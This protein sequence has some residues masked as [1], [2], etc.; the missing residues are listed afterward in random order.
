MDTEDTRTFTDCGRVPTVCRPRARPQRGSQHGGAI[1]IA[2]LRRAMKGQFRGVREMG[3]GSATSR[4]SGRFSRMR[5]FGQVGECSLQ[6]QQP[7]QRWSG[8]EALEVP[9]HCG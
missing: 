4:E 3:A 5:G 1:A 8:K 7:V 2:V 6:G 9:V